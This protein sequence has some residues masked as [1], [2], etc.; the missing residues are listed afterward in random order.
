MGLLA[1]HYGNTNDKLTSQWQNHMLTNKTKHWQ[2]P[3]HMLDYI[4]CHS[5]NK[6]IKMG[7]SHRQTIVM[8][9]ILIIE[10]SSTVT[11][12]LE[13]L[14]NQ[15]PKIEVHFLPASPKVKRSIMFIKRNYSSPLLILIYRMPLMVK[16]LTISSASI[17]QSLFSQEFTTK[18]LENP[19]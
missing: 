3:H 5:K 4:W 10:D 19:C 6:P 18:K 16:R 2:E 9:K 7:P 8:K 15:H 12:I 1:N 17:C 13:H 11:K 14:V